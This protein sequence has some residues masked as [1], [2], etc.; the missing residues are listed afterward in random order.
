M[1]LGNIEKEN[2]KDSGVLNKD[3]FNENKDFIEL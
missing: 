3:F 1:F 2:N